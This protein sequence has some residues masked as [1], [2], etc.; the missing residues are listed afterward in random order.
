[1]TKISLS[2]I[3]LSYNVKQKLLDCLASIPKH[4]DWEV[5]VV[6]NAS[7]DGSD[8]LAHI[9]S[10]T[11]IGFAAGNNLGIR[12]T[13]GEYILLLNSDTIVYSK[14]IETVLEY[15]QTHPDVGVAT[16][17][18]ELPDGTLDYS[19]HRKFPDPVG[20]FLHLIGLKQ[21]SSYT[22]QKIPNSIHE[23]DALTGAFALIRREAGEQVNWLDEDYFFNGEDID[24]CYKLKE[25]GW[26]VM[27]IPNV[28]ITHHKLSSIK[29]SPASRKRWVTDST[30]AMR[31]FYSKHLSQKYPFF[32]NWTV[33]LGIWLLRVARLLTSNL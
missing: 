8:K 33:Y 5:L 31:I 13:K 16:C 15:M 27:Y 3:I 12:R 21:I 4:P 1:M 26:K 24:F 28:K 17:R 18:V 9:T 25:A 19:C 14:T 29:S 23:I 22:N 10:K 2:I 32:V 30:N 6:D 11:N 20:S 7:T